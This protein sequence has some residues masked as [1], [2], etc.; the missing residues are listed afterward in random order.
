MV[1]E[2][3]RYFSLFNNLMKNIKHLQFKKGH[4][5]LCYTRSKKKIRN[6]GGNT[7]RIQDQVF[8]YGYKFGL[9]IKAIGVPLFLG[10]KRGLIEDTYLSVGGARSDGLFP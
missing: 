3:L 1:L 6:Q 2:P 4:I 10:L 7:G 9:S 8:I 5:Q